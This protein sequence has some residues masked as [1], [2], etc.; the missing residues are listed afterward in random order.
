[1]CGRFALSILPHVLERTFGARPPEDWPARWNIAPDSLILAVRA[2]RDG[3]GREAAPLRWGMLGPWMRDAKDPARQINARAETAAEKPMFR[4][5]FA[6]GRCVIPADGF[7]E[8]RKQGKEAPSRPHFIRRRDGAPLALAGLWRANRLESGEILQSCAILT[9][10]AHPALRAIH[11]RMPAML[12]DEALEAWLDPA[13]RDPELLRAIL[14]E[15]LPE[16]ALEAYE[17][18]REVNNPRRDDAGLVRHLS[19][20]GSSAGEDEPAQPSLL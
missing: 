13:T 18:G 10:D 20:A 3:E 1:M 19:A 12:R 17:V 16:P 2:R 7:Y 11:H 8:W 14:L 6:K 15:P 4:D 5:S 9:T